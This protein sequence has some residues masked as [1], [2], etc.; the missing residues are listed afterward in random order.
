LCSCHGKEYVIRHVDDRLVPVG[1]KIEAHPSHSLENLDLR[2]QAEDD[3]RGFLDDYRPP[4]ILDEIQRVPSIFSYL[5]ERVDRNQ[6]PAQYILTGSHQFL[7]MEKI[8]QSL[9]GRIVTFKL[10]PFSFAEFM[11]QPR[12]KSI[13][14]IFMPKFDKKPS[15]TFSIEQLIFQ[16]MYPRIHDKNLSP[17]KWIEDYI[18]TYVE[19][20]VRTLINVD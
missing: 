16:G 19:R 3:P 13:E 12:D 20:D 2:Q 4:V 7:R 14:D 6:D 15:K 10:F 18:L 5:Q 1:L 8:T 17:R 9:A 11:K